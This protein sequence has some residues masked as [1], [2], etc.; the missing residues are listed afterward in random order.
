MTEPTRSSLWI[1]RLSAF[2][3][4]SDLEVSA[5]FLLRLQAEELTRRRPLSDLDAMEAFDASRETELYPHQIY[6][7]HFAISNPLLKGVGL[8]DDVGLGKTIEA[9]MILKEL[10]YRGKHNLLVVASK[11]LR[12]QWAGELRAR[13]NLAFEVLDGE[14]VRELQNEGLN[15]FV[16]LRIA[17]YHFVHK[18]IARFSQTHWDAVIVDEAHQLKNP[19]GALHCS[20]NRLQRNFTVLVTATPIQN[21]LP[22]L[23]SLTRLIDE[24]M[25]GTAFSFKENFC[26]DDRGLH[27]QNVDELKKRL[28]Q[29]AIRTLRSDVPEINFTERTSKLYDF[30]LP[31]DERRLYECVSDYLSRDSCAF[32]RNPSIL[33]LIVYRKLLASSSFALLSALRKLVERLEEMKEDI[34]SRLEP[35][36]FKV[37]DIGDEAQAVARELDEEGFEDSSFTRRRPGNRILNELFQL[38]RLEGFDG[39]TFTLRCLHAIREIEEELVE[40]RG[41]VRLCETIRE[42]AKAV[43]L[44]RVMPELL[45]HGNKVLIFTQFKATQRYLART[46]RDANYSVVEFSGDLKSHPNPERDEREQAKQRFRDSADVMIATDAGAEGLNLQFCHIVV[47]YDLPWNPMKIEQRIGRCH[48]IGQKYDVVVVN[49]VALSNA[50][51]R[52]LVDLLTDKIHLFESVLG[53]TEEILGTIEDGISF[54]REIFNILQNCRTPQEI[55]RAFERLQ[56]ECDQVIRERLVR[57]ASLLQQGFDDRIKEHL[58]VAQTNAQDALDRRTSQLR[59]FL[60]DSLRALSG[61]VDEQDG[62]LSIATPAEYK[63][64]KP[65]FLEPSY[66]GT[67]NRETGTDTIPYFDK[68]HP[69]VET[70]LSLHRSRGERAALTLR[71]SGRHNIHGIEE[72][73]GQMGWWMNFR[74]SFT[75]FEVEDH[76]LSLAFVNGESSWEHHPMLSENIN[77]ITAEQGSWTEVLSFPGSDTIEQVLASSVNRIRGEIDERNARYYLDRRAILDR[78]YGDKGD[79]EILAE[80]RHRVREKRKEMEEIEATI[81]VAP[82][83]TAKIVRIRQKDRLDEEL[84]NLEEKLHDE[85]R[86][87]FEKKC[88]ESRKLEQ[89]RQLQTKVELVNVAQ[90]QL[91]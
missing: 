4:Q 89:L 70:A 24:H 90:W 77:R 57:G 23:H 60:L 20:V 67:F 65:D 49:L 62:V 3:K 29:F 72:L 51:E 30:V 71:Y 2:I 54:E 21:Y 39:S 84:F 37:A 10:H 9:A 36:P 68:H 80:L 17:T 1:E 14:S 64:H 44:A 48:R 82:S 12:Q 22:E 7:A 66:R 18:H 33:I 75:G 91:E 16:G 59:C 52:R 19:Q 41:Y 26:A 76:L 42:N 8:F 25:L 11:S 81:G 34:K 73:V 69:L 45:R 85:Q 40:V 61:A 46:L 35:K 13:F 56:R 27:P 5:S 32:G 86:K 15:P 87:N 74:G 28:S 31:P 83:N 38:F 50:V 47:N 58:R 79:G 63:L 88:E 43:K 6:A 53:E 78:F 55:D